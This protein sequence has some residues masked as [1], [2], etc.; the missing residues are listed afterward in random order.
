MFCRKISCP[1]AASTVE[2]ITAIILTLST[3]TPA[4][5]AM[6][7][8]CPTALKSCPSFV[9][10]RRKTAAHRRATMARVR[11]GKLMLFRYLST[12]MSIPFARIT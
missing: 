12:G 10:K 3:F 4:T 9:L 7:L 5:S 6:C 1:H 2:N 11:T 8:F